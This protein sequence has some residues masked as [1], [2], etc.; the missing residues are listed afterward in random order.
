MKCGRPQPT[1]SCLAS[2]RWWWKAD[3]QSGV[4]PP[5][6][7]SVR[8]EVAHSR[9]QPDKSAGLWTVKSDAPLV[10]A[11]RLLV[12]FLPRAARRPVAEEVRR[13]YVAGV[14]ARLKAGDCFESAMR[15]AYRT[16]LSSSDFLFH[17]ES[18]Q[19]PSSHL[20]H[21]TKG[22]NGTDATSLDDHALASR[23]SY[24]LWNSAPDARRTAHA[25]RGHWQTPRLAPQRSRAPA[26]RREIAALH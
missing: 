22:T 18:H 12:N 14:E 17:M 4:R 21:G 3:A 11:D 19:S 7:K 25:T 20:S 23:L 8:Q 15:W 26:R 24:F 9:N 6:R 5:L 13:K 10:D 16:A 1:G 2:C